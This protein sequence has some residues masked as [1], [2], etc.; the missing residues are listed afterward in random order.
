[1]LPIFCSSFRTFTLQHNREKWINGKAKQNKTVYSGK[2]IN[3]KN[4]N[5]MLNLI[6]IKEM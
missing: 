4:I 2:F 3:D 5:M 1:M 6:E